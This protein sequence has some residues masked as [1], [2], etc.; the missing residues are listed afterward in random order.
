MPTKVKISNALLCE[1][2]IEGLGN[3]HTLINVFTGDILVKSF[4]ARLF[5]G[6]YLE[7]YPTTP[8]GKLSID[9][10]LGSKKFA[11]VAVEYENARL[12]LPGALVIP[13][14]EIGLDA[15]DTLEFVARAEGQPK[16]RILKKT[17]SLMGGPNDPSA[18]LPPS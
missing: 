6:L 5:F 1:H 11:E 17:I 10:I 12:G 13:V 7:H 14:F 15:P 2:V 9:I 18:S 3:K 8:S 4:P 16:V